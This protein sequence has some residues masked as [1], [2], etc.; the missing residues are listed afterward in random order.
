MKIKKEYWH[1]L[2]IVM[3]KLRLHFDVI[4]LFGITFVLV[5]LYILVP[6]ILNKTVIISNK[7]FTLVS[8]VKFY[9]VI[10]IMIMVILIVQD[11]LKLKIDRIKEV[12]NG[13][14][15]IQEKKH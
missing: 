12:T 2:V 10:L 9:F 3:D 15:I 7:A 1:K 5:I 11:R 8:A 4:A 6:N 14:K 13:S